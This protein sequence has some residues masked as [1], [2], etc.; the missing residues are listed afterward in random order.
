MFDDS[1]GCDL[2][3]GVEV[4]PGA[5]LAL[6][7][8]D[9]AEQP[10]GA[11]LEALEHGR[12]GEPRWIVA[13]ARNAS[14]A[15][16]I[17]RRAAADGRRSGYVAMSVELY[18]R[19][20]TLL[21]EELAERTLLL[22]GGFA[23]ALPLAR[24]ALVAAAA[25]APRPHVL[26]T[27]R[28]GQGAGRA[29]C[30]REAHAA[31]GAA[32]VSAHDGPRILGSEFVKYAG[33]IERAVT[34]A[35]SGRHAAAE[36][37]LRETMG[38]LVRRR[39]FGLAAHAVTVLGSQ[40]VERGRVKDAD[41]VFGEA[42]GLGHRA[43]SES[44]TLVARVWQAAVRCDA[45]RCTE[46]EALC[47]AAVIAGALS[48]A[49]A[50]WARAELAR[51]LLW[52]GRPEADVRA[53]TLDDVARDELGAATAAFVDGVAVRLS[54]ASGH[55]FDAG[56][57]ARAAVDR[58]DASADPLARAIAHTAQ[59]RVLVEGGDLTCASAAFERVRDAAR[60]AHAP[61][62][63]ARARLVW[64]DALRRGGQVREADRH[65]ASL[66]RLGKAVPASLRGGAVGRASGRLA[67]G[68]PVSGHAAPGVLACP[69]MA[70]SLVRVAQDE[71]DDAAAVGRVTERMAQAL[72]ASRIDVLSFDAGPTTTLF[73][74]GTGLPTHI[75]DRVLQ[76]GITI[77]P[78]VHDG[79][80]EIGVPV[81]VGTRL[82][83]ALAARWPLDRTPP[84]QA[85]DVLQLG[86]AVL[87]PRMEQH[88]AGARTRASAATSVPELIGVSGG[89]VDVRRAI[90]RAAAAPFAVLIEGESGVGKELAARAIHQ[91]SPR[92]ERRF[93]DVNCAAIPEELL[94]SELFGHACGAFTGAVA[95]RAG[96][97]EEADGGT[98][99]LDEVADLSPRG[100][101]KLLRVV[102]QHEVRRV[103]ETFSRKVD[104]R[105]V[106]AAN[107][108]MRREAADGRFRQ[109]LLYRL[110]VIRIHIP[111]LR[112]RPDDIGVLA[113]HFWRGV[114]A[115]VGS[116]ATL[117]HGVLAELMRYPW[118]GNARELQNVVAALAVAAPPKGRVSPSLLPAAIT[119]AT[120]V[121]SPQLAEARAQFE[122]RCVEVA[123]ARA[124][125]NRTQAAA[126][127]GLTR[128]G[129]LKTMTRLGL[130]PRGA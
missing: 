5:D 126:Q 68:V 55:V 93:C 73:T 86:A 12:E 23:G 7:P 66:A 61:L 48:S 53:L 15:A 35:Y 97:F 49:R 40:L 47:R 6:E 80:N 26:L 102:Q 46:A 52:Q 13:D 76:A 114:S 3:T 103:G 101:A 99:F 94:D 24:S 71:D 18:L 84:D 110:D 115:R 96:L 124:S 128:Q 36:R 116:T 119:G 88:L 121:L 41:G 106:T 112:D 65:L 108:D 118:P 72:Q 37:L 45:G 9:P 74:Y 54:L 42:A 58:A 130:D 32:M 113:E 20:R 39:A 51:V 92:R 111:P 34:F 25:G 91:L 27:F 117:T 31:Y 28:S 2:V 82:L 79:G 59:L 69:S 78:E 127:L 8:R 22:I 89:I 81:R 109:D 44:A 50:T 120:R 104:V 29:G 10:S 21:T 38:A 95:E 125:G 75:G 123:L 90:A 30:V 4:V 11:F 98:L 70:A 77:G 87:A 122:R 105:L 56:Q 85:I 60:Q 57:R 64:S 33:Y 83:A 43:Q 19:F 17:A 67:P 107:R 129:L 62:R 14:H 100:Q 63:L 1:R 16:A